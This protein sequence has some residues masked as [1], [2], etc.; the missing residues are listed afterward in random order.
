MIE[1][2]KMLAGRLYLASDAELTRERALCQRLLRKLNRTTI[3]RAA[4]SRRILERLLGS[5]G[6]NALIERPFRCD[7]GRNIFAGDNLFI[8]YNCTILDVCPVRIGDNVF[9]APNV[10]IYT[11][12]HPIDSELRNTQL[13]CGRPVTI[14]SNVWIGGNTVINPGVRIG[15]NVVIGSGSVVTKDIPDN[16]IAVGNPCTVKR[17]ITQADKENWRTLVE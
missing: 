15:A 14:G 5:I 10:S 3:F 16:C 2:E 13:E 12:E 7:Y 6:K 11:A 17:N 9:I 4:K 1:K 8:N